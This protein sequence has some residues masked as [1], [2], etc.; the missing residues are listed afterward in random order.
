MAKKTL[1][2]MIRELI[3]KGATNAEDVHKAIAEM[4]LKQLAKIDGLSGPIK[5]VFVKSCG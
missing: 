1:I 2:T 5:R 4:P 3:E